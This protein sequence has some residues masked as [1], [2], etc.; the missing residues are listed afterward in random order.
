MPMDRK[1]VLI[2]D[3]YNVIRNNPRYSQLGADYEAS[4]S[5]NKAR[6]AVI[7]DAALMAKG[8]YDHCTVVFDG[9]GNSKSKGKPTRVCGID[10]VF[11]PAGVSADTVIERLAHDAREAVCGRLR[12]RI[13]TRGRCRCSAPSGRAARVSA[14][15]QVGNE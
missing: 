2:V 1:V 5:W 12:R 10:V 4:S 8:S 9:A 15:C 11:S 14:M 3:G 6:E 7:N 13:P